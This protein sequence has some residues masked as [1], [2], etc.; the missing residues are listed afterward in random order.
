MSNDLDAMLGADF[1][2]R[3]QALSADVPLRA[4]RNGYEL[5]IPPPLT[6]SEDQPDEF[7]LPGIITGGGGLDEQIDTRP[8]LTQGPEDTWRDTARMDTLN[9]LQEQFGWD[10]RKARD[11]AETLWGTSGDLSKTAFGIGVADLLP[12]VSAPLT[13]QE[14]IQTFGE[15]METGSGTDMALGAVLTAAGALESIPVIGAGFKMLNKAAQSEVVKEFITVAGDAFNRTGEITQDALIEAGEAAQARLD[16]MMSGTTLSANP[17]GA[18]GD[19]IVAGAGKVASA[20][21]P[22][23]SLPQFMTSDGYRFYQQKD[24]TLTDNPNPEMS[25]M[26]F[27]SLQSI[28]DDFGEMPLPVGKNEIAER[29][30]KAFVDDFSSFMDD[31]PGSLPEDVKQQR[32]LNVQSRR[33]SFTINNDEVPS[34]REVLIKKSEEMQLKPAKRVQPTDDQMFDVAPESYEQGIVP[35][36]Q[37]ETPVPRA[38]AGAKLPKKG[39]TQGLVDNMEEIADRIAERAR[40]HVGTNVQYF[41]HLGPLLK[42]AEDLGIPE[43]EA[44]EAIKEFSLLYGATSPRTQTEPNLRSASLVR[45]KDKQ[46]IRYDEIVGPGGTGINEAGFPMMINQAKKGQAAGIHKLLIDQLRTTGKIDYK[47][48]PK[49]ATFAENV[50]G[51]LNGVTVDT[52]AIRGALYMLNDIMPGSIPRQW[53]NS[54]TA[55]K[56]YL[57]DPSNIENYAGKG[58]ADT[59]DGQVVDGSKQQ[60]EYAIFSDI[61]RMV[62]DRLGVQPAEAQSLSWFANGEFT[63]LASPPKTIVELINERVDV[64]AQAL[65]RSKDAIFKA[66]IEGKIPLMSFGGALVGVGMLEQTDGN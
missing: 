30:S 36:M 21:K 33:A 11:F 24:G 38:P 55:Y 43:D 17:V 4:T 52:H 59:L 42:K 13:M 8:S 49:P 40:P 31:T 64:T 63:G 1:D 32:A 29:S 14:G 2:I 60:T 3:Q 23:A 25:D 27:D 51:N 16:S 6:L 20:M 53:F 37:I 5:D 9:F 58:I 46:N 61:Y 56:A 65:G 7:G 35:E 19:A 45:A 50:G 28:A 18:A 47:T 26:T 22:D 15:G 54:E 66:F 34:L 48:N 12:P 57:D 41:Y 10:T 44:R 39:R 62:A